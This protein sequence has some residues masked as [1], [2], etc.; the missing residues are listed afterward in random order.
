MSDSPHPWIDMTFPEAAQVARRRR[1]GALA[2]LAIFI[3]AP[4]LAQDPAARDSVG[5]DDRNFSF[6]AR[7]PYRSAVPRPEAILGYD[8]GAQNTQFLMQERVLL[9]IADA[10]KD[11]VRV[12]QIGETAERRP[13]RL[14]IVSSPENIQRL[15][16]IR[17]DLDRLGDPRTLGAADR[18]A[19]VARTPAVV[20]INESVHGNEAPGF[21]TAMQTLYQLAASDEPATV[22]ALRNVD[23][24]TTLLLLQSSSSSGGK[25]HYGVQQGL[26]YCA[27]EPA[28]ATS[29][30]RL[31][32][33]PY[34]PARHRWMRIREQLGTLYFEY[35]GDGCAWSLLAGVPTPFSV[36]LVSVSL[37]AMTSL[38][39]ASPGV[40][41][42][43][44]AQVRHAYTPGV[45]R[46]VFE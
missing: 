34:D 17:A 11:R 33:E 12:E 4:A 32:E 29:P 14:Y 30:T 37:F 22:Q 10:A 41:V 16:A 13:M 19:I 39:V 5:R 26:F 35:S 38:A 3:A 36:S 21:E 45:L 44:N 6:Y 46:L 42:F 43:D 20:W 18:D 31:A 2:L 27:K 1:T 25:L 15:D 7:G 40:A 9:A 28:G 24:A 23:G 8:V